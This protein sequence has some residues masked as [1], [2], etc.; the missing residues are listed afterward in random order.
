MLMVASQ[1]G[2]PGTHVRVEVTPWKHLSLS[3]LCV[4]RGVG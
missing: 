2:L 3:Q 4:T 1:H